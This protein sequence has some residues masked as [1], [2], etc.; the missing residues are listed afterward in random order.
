MDSRYILAVDLGTSGCKTALVSLEGRVAGWA[1]A[2]VP[3]H[4]L[5]GG[6]AE[7]VPADWWA[8]FVS[9]TRRVLE[10]S[11]VSPEAVAAVCCSCQGEGTV[12]V[13]RDGRALMNAIT[14]ADMRGAARIRAHARGWLNFAGYDARRLLRWVRITGG[15]PSLTG[16]DPAAHMLLVRDEFPDVY[17][18]TYKFLNVLDYLNLRLTGRFVATHDSILTSWVTDNRDLRRVR[19]HPALLEASGIDADKFP[20]LVPLHRRDRN[21]AARGG[22]GARAP[23]RDAGGGRGGGQHGGGGRL[24]R[25]GRLRGAPLHRDLVLDRRARALQEDRRVRQHGLGALRAVRTAT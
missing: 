7:Q 20:E 4:I 24:G 18:A 6:G 21:A 5:P 1:F 17:R 23:R 13:D 8:A 3:L 22:V 15:A 2:Q 16:K 14:W 25:A 10:H 12:P 19:Y 9:T 11:G